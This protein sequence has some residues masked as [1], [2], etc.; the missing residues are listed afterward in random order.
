[1]SDGQLSIWG[2]GSPPAET[3]PVA[4][5]RVTSAARETERLPADEA[6]R[7]R[8]VSEVDRSC[9]VEASAGTGKTRLLV[10]RILHIVG[11]G[12]GQ[13]P[14]LVAITFT[15]KAASELRTRVRTEIQAAA[16]DPER[17]GAERER[18]AS[19]LK[20]FDRATVATIHAFCTQLL[21]ARP[22]EAGVSPGFSLTSRV[23]SQLLLD[24]AWNAW[25][26]REL[27]SPD[28]A[29]R[30]VLEAGGQLQYLRSLAGVLVE[31]RDL[32]ETESANDLMNGP[33]PEWEEAFAAYRET[34]VES[35]L[36]EI[37]RLLADC[38]KP[39][40]D[41]AC[42]D[43][44]AALPA[45]RRAAQRIRAVDPRAPYHAF[46]ATG[47]PNPRGSHK[48]NLLNWKPRES[49]VRLRILIGTINEACERFTTARKAR[50]AV[51]AVRALGGLLEIY[52]GLKSERGLLDFQD[53]LI[54]SRNLLRDRP[55]VRSDFQASISHLL[56]DEFQ[57]TDP[58]QA[59]IVFFLSG[60][61]S[62][63]E[64][65]WERVRVTPGRLFLVGDPKQ[66]IYRFRRADIG[67]Y[68]R[69]RRRLAE[70][71]GDVHPITVNFRTRPAITEWINTVFDRLMPRD[72][73]GEFRPAYSRLEPHRTEDDGEPGPRVIRL[74]LP[75][76]PKSHAKWKT[77]QDEEPRRRVEA[78][79]L[80]SYVK[81]QI[82]AGAWTLPVKGSEG[83]TAPAG[84][85]DVA[86]L[87]RALTGL[88]SFE[89]AFRDAGVPY[90]I[91]GGKYYFQRREV[92]GLLSVLR[93]IDSP[94]DR[95]A[96]VAALRSPL[97]GFDDE[98]IVIAAAEH[99]LNYGSRSRPSS[100]ELAGV[101]DR[102]RDWHERRHVEG[103]ETIV[104]EVLRETK[105][106]E[107]FAMQPLGEQR[108]ANLLK[109]VDEA[110][111]YGGEPG[112]Y[113]A[114]I[115]HLSRREAAF[116]SEGESPV[117]EEDE[118]GY[119]HFLTVHKAK[120]LEFPIVVVADL[121]G[122]VDSQSEMRFDRASA[123]I[124][125]RLKA[126]REGPGDT[127]GWE[128]LETIDK[129]QAE[130]EEIRLFYVAVTRAREFLILPLPESGSGKGSFYGLVTREEWPPNATISADGPIADDL[131]PRRTVA[132]GDLVPSAESEAV[133][134]ARREFAERRAALLDALPLAPR[135][136]SPSLLKAVTGG[137]TVPPPAA[138]R[139]DSSRARAL[140][141]LVH[142]ALE[143]CDFT[144]DDHAAWVERLLPHHP[145]LGDPDRADIARLL[146][147]AA[148]H[149][150][151]ARA[152]NAR[153][154]LREVP[155]S[156]RHRE[157]VYVDG[158]VDLLIEEADGLT[159]VDFK[160]DRT[161]REGVDA[162]FQR[163]R[164][165]ALAYAIGVTK[166]SGMP[167]RE[168]VF[169]FL[170]GGEARSLRVDDA[171]LAEAALL[172]DPAGPPAA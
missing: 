66:S 147:S 102:L 41:N 38:R 137:A 52:E 125:F 77:K 94:N 14:N 129:A 84:Y 64:T 30:P 134:Q 127:P 31:N 136:V 162:I 126:V 122:G 18:F 171:L 74:P 48:G 144:G 133:D 62:A 4:D 81:A 103:P 158:M 46:R 116:E 154:V 120:G 59:E 163:Y 11:T 118:G 101:F 167:V 47:L 115:E 97:F 86:V 123:K 131:F 157:G 44:A 151:M 56:V 50:A 83:E 36:D 82:E 106:L 156:Y 148:D 37:E 67:I 138:S 28:S 165:Q 19:A 57:D 108:V 10:H 169:L 146:R 39:L 71:G 42:R 49:L 78:R 3:P 170:D 168:V 139:R 58:L 91:E 35:N 43:V 172:L 76:V 128:D 69:A 75:E 16:R 109:V 104:E 161:G 117:L 113:R 95:E 114:F 21:R 1:M 141:Q 32:L 23:E 143:R 92:Q 20:D 29:L 80:A 5:S 72:G 22:V 87:F 150:V 145:P 132:P 90:R 70:S 160:T 142:G 89:D 79:V 13:L 107:F 7:R 93:A 34:L 15:E 60:D 121:M 99:R 9:L 24:E 140:G 88:D 8:I 111:R 159:V 45:L 6:V 55:D 40:E 100:P 85:G 53:L 51:E 2:D 130:A 152:R 33:L 119:V 112:S 105:A 124:A 12:A 149:P 166:A 135:V 27:G 54:K 164:G 98:T 73:S 63:G 68:E 155:F 65:D 153:R 61:L 26:E 96:L 17:S 110:R 25:K